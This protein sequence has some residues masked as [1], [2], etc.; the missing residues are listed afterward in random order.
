MVGSARFS[1]LPV[2]GVA[3]GGRVGQILLDGFADPRHHALHVGLVGPGDADVP[4]VLGGC[5]QI[6]GQRVNDRLGQ[7]DDGVVERD[8]VEI[9]VGLDRD[10]LRQ[11]GHVRS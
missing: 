5:K 3:F 8:H 11:V 1:D 9:H 2:D 10:V 4:V 7:R 6:P